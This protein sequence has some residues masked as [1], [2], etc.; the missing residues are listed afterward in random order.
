MLDATLIHVL[1]F[2]FFVVVFYHIVLV[3]G[4]QARFIGYINGVK[5]L[6]K[7]MTQHFKISHPAT[8]PRHFRGE[9]VSSFFDDNYSEYREPLLSP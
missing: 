7:K 9:L 5:K 4:Q 8:H 1:I 3:T 2:T 6:M